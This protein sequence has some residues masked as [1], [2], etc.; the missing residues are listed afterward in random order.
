MIYEKG[1][2][3]KKVR[4]ALS[5]FIIQF[6]FNIA[7]SFIFFGAREPKLALIEIIVLWFLIL[8]TIVKFYKISKTAGLILLPYLAWVTFATLLNWSV[9]VLNNF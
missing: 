9:V 8:V 6:A 4:E 3:N 1:M 2:K 5:I 7:W